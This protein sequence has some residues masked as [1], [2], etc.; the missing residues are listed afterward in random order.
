MLCEPAAK[1]LQDN[2]V[3]TFTNK[4]EES[5]KQILAITRNLLF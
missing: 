2:Y 5:S 3:E 4:L 1:P